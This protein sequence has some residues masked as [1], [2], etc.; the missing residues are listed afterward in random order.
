M[1]LDVVMNFCGLWLFWR[2]NWARFGYQNPGSD[3]LARRGHSLLTLPLSL[4]LVGWGELWVP[5]MWSV[6]LRPGSPNRLCSAQKPTPVSWRSNDS[7][8]GVRPC[9]RN[10][11]PCVKP[12]WSPVFW[13]EILLWSSIT[14]ID[15]Q[16]NIFWKLIRCQKF[17]EPW[18]CDH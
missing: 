7:D 13:P 11:G 1:S 18:E 16:R 5:S 12:A 6:P 17:L 9:G 2:L 3:P 14:C 15:I 8:G 10:R 4:R